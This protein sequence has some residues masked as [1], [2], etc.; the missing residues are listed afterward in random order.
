MEQIQLVIDDL[1]KKGIVSKQQFES[2]REESKNKGLPINKVLISKGIVKEKDIASVISER[3]GIPFM[4]LSDYL[5]DADV[6]KLVPESIA[7]RYKLIPLF[8]IGQTLTV[9]MADP[10]D[11]NAMDQ[12]RLKSGCEIDAV[13]ATETDIKNAMDQYYGTSGGVEE[14]IKQM[15]EVKR[16]APVAPASDKELAKMAEDAPVV[17]LVNMIIIQAVTEKAS[18]IHIEPDEKVLRVRYRVDGIL[19]EVP[20]PPKDLEAAIISRVKVLAS[21]DIAERRK[22]QDGRI[23]MKMQGKD[24]DMRVSCFPTVYGENIVIRLLDKTSLLLGLSELG[25]R[26]EMHKAF[27]KIIRKPFGIMLVTGPTGSGKTTTLYAA[28]NT[29]NSEEKNIITIEDPVE[30]QISMIRQTQVNPKAELTFASGLRSILRQDPD[31]IMV[32]EIRDSETAEIATQAALTGHLVF[33]TLHTNDASGAITRLADMGI[34]PFLISDAVIGVLAQRLVRVIC[35]KCKEKLVP[36]DA[37][38]KDLKLKRS[39]DLAL[40]HGKGCAKCK[41]TGY[42]GRVGI[43]ELLIIDDELRKLI[44]A[45]APADQ[46]K[47]KAVELGMKT[48][49][50]DGIAKALEGITS[51]EEVLRVASEE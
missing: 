38:L 8:K 39:D 12:V 17:K 24:I 31:V 44:I 47:A 48:L 28:L 22:P 32:G 41:D 1:I 3:L 2:A 29:I 49:Y 21:M 19:H 40:Y 26:P 10:Q 6:I 34:E 15:N 14:V 42:V 4:D 7:Q 18:D 37:T 16:S 30:Y 11:I 36:T 20:K 43:Y 35:P 45:K 51:V 25:M 27:D 46:I 9:A 33:S 13:L 23:M 5:I 50:E